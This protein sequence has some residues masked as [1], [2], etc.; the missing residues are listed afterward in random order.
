MNLRELGRQ[1]LKE[2][3]AHFLIAGALVFALLS[4][5]PPDPGERR[6]VVDEALV[7]RLAERWVM[8]YRRPPAPQELDGM[9]ADYVRE[10]VYYREA[11]RLGLDRGDEV[12]IKRMRN[13]M[14]AL[15]SAEAEARE[16]SDAELQALLDRDPA[17]YAGEPRYSLVQVY[18]GNDAASAPQLLARLKGGASPE[19]MG[20]IAPLPQGYAA[21]TRAELAERFGDAFPAALDRLR[22]GEWTGPIGSGLGQH[23][24][25]LERRDAAPPPRV[26]DIRQRLSNDWRAA[27]I[28]AAQDADYRRLLEGYEVTIE[29][30]GA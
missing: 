13:K 16:P 21:A 28:K 27:A 20:A 6:I 2:P 19:G 11:L 12:V 14:L 29:K 4:G 30:P 10:Q 23:L 18:L 5:R 22:P 1:W 26:A 9:I 25:R 8:T 7:T 15:A 17:R 24:V 3:L